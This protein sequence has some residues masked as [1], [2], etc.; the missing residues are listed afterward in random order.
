VNAGEQV[1][2]GK[3][4]VRSDRNSGAAGLIVRMKSGEP[5][6]FVLTCAHVLGAKVLDS[7]QAKIEKDSVYCVHSRVGV[8]LRF[9]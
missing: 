1:T 8:D 9:V 6:R 4:G 7:E 5:G 3:H 2:R